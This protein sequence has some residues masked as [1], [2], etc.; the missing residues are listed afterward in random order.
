MQGFFLLVPLWVKLAGLRGEPGALH[1]FQEAASRIRPG[2]S[3]AAA[4]ESVPL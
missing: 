1:P 2:T 3:G 4:A